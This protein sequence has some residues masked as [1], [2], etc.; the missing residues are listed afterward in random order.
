MPD[1]EIQITPD[2]LPFA[3]PNWDGEFGA[4]IS[5]LGVVRSR[6]RDSE[7]A[8]IEYTAYRPMVEKALRDLGAA[9]LRTF[10]R[11]RAKITHRTG[12]VAVAEPSVDIRVST[13]HSHDA[14]VICR[15]YL[16]E[17]KS[18]IPIW[19]QIIPVSDEQ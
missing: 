11:H 7:I 18:K 15:W 14:F 2:P 8:G 4:E 19:K 5:F 13:K 16:A 12:F 10:G 9:A 1:F 3:P 6:E 17:L